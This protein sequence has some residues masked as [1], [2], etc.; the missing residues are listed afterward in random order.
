M[1]TDYSLSFVLICGG[2]FLLV[3]AK[4]FI[5]F[6]KLQKQEFEY[7]KSQDQVQLPLNQDTLNLLDI[8]IN[9]KWNDTLAHNIDLTLPGTYITKPLEEA[10]RKELTDRVRMSLTEFIYTK[11]L[12]VYDKNSVEKIISEKIYN[13][14]LAFKIT[15]STT[16]VESPKKK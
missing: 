4:Q 7:S 3:T 14:V 2:I 10:L 15:Q 8:I 11:L 9:I 16:E 5:D 12:L 13:T 6:I 1:I